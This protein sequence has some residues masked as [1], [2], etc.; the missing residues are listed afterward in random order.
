M[1]LQ[2]RPDVI[3]VEYSFFRN[4]FE[5]V[6]TQ[7]TNV[8]IGPDEHGKVA[9]KRANTS[10]A[11]GFVEMGSVPPALIARNDRHRQK[12][13]KLC[14]HHHRPCP[15]PSAAMWCGKRFV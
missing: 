15:R 4:L 5:P 6:F 12:R 11:L 2:T 9:K 8:G 7:F 14:A 3:G 1:I 13:F 10:D